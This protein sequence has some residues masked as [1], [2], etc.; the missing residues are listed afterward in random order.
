MSVGEPKAPFEP[1]FAAEADTLVKADCMGQTLP[2][3]QLH[4][5]YPW[6]QGRRVSKQF[7]KQPVAYPM[8]SGFGGDRYRQIRK[9]VLELHGRH[10]T[11]LYHSDQVGSVP[12]AK[13]KATCQSNLKSLF[14]PRKIHL[15]R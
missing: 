4:P 13:C 7:D 12:S 8:S 1:T 5:L 15:F 6:R 2:Y 11:G 3:Y 10:A 14:D 9:Y